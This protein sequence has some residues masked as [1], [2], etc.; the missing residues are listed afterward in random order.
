MVE[1]LK[2]RKAMRRSKVLAAGAKGRIFVVYLITWCLFLVVGMVEMPLAMI[3]GFG[4]LKGE[5]HVLL[6]VAILCVNFMAHS[7]V[8][9]VLMIGLSL[10]YFDQRVRQDGLDLLL[11]LDGGAGAGV[12]GAGASSSAPP[13]LQAGEPASD[14][15]AL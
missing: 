5:R 10:V 2:V 7:M 14:A 4:A 11:M 6:Q 13:T 1:E 9:P 8:T 15:A 3:V 12:N